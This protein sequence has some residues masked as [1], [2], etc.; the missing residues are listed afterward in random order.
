MCVNIAFIL[1][2]FE[3]VLITL[4]PD[5]VLSSFGYSLILSFIYSFI[6]SFVCS[7]WDTVKHEFPF[8]PIQLR[9]TLSK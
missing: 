1:S 7:L 5:F 3:V 4:L 2:F 9:F 8:S 6:H